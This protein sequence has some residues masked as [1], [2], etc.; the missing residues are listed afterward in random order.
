MKAVSGLLK[1]YDAGLQIKPH[2]NDFVELYKTHIDLHD[3]LN[4]KI[5]TSDLDH[6]LAAVDLV[7]CED[8]SAIIDVM[9]K[10]KLVIMAHFADSEPTLPVKI[11]DVVP[12][13]RNEEE[14]DNAVKEILALDEDKLSSLQKK[15]DE[16][17]EY[18]VGTIT[19]DSTSK[20]IEKIYQIMH[21]A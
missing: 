16:F 4:V 9:L 13:A 11:F 6:A 7:I 12:I 15:R 1:K 21:S 5:S 17:I 10:G 2:S 20:T 18:C 14:L 8:S 3:N 19:M